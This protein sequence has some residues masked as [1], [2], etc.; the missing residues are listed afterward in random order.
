VTVT[1]VR[2][3]AVA[4]ALALAAAAL[5]LGLCWVALALIVRAYLEPLL[6]LAR[7]LTHGG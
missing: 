2:R 7:L 3:A 4:T 6:V 5:T 1:R